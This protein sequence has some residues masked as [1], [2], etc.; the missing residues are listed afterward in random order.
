[1]S[2]IYINM[3][4]KSLY[5]Q[6]TGTVSTNELLTLRNECTLKFILQPPEETF[7]IIKISPYWYGNTRT[8][9]YAWKLESVESTRIHRN[10]L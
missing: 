3:C 6:T 8:E 10:L 1:M 5:A 7:L 9:E 4:N 2:V